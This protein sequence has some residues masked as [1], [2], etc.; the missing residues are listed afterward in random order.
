MHT[1]T[2]RVATSH[3]AL[4][5]KH[6]TRLAQRNPATP[7][8]TID[9]YETLKDGTVNAVL[10]LT[11]AL[12]SNYR[13]V[14][15][16]DD[17]ETRMIR[18]I[19]GEEIPHVYQ[20]ARLTC[21]HCQA[22]RQRL[23]AYIVRDLTTDNL[24]MVGSSCLDKILDPEAF[25]A[26][27]AYMGIVDLCDDLEGGSYGG[28]IA[29]R[30]LSQY[31]T[32]VAALVLELGFLS[33]GKAREAGYASTAEVAWTNYGPIPTDAKAEALAEKALTYIGASTEESDYMWNLRQIVKK[34]Y[35]SQKNAG[36]A[37]S[38]ISAYQ[39][40]VAKEAD[41]TAAK[42][43]EFVASVGEK[44]TF[45]ITLLK[46]VSFDTQYGTSHL[47]LMKDAAGNSIVWK[48]GSVC[49]QDKVGETFHIAGTVKGHDTYR[50]VKQT[51]LVRV[52]E[53]SADFSYAKPK[54][55]SRKKATV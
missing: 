33:Q 35:I 11:S 22:N 25:E 28:G 44:V 19:S 47:H 36:F 3:L 50:E 26:F 48:T 34:P 24:L 40:H 53:V 12:S 14:A 54:K 15:Q 55:A 27:E 39:N 30:D 38:M 5:E 1:S 9:S 45:P 10:T 7:T 29:T 51:S 46:V 41:R 43:S 20:T 17:S 23:Y 4:F 6:Y 37:A 21:D 2:L 32:T 31:L 49:W 13:V 16:I 42:A 52:A 8:Y 18:S